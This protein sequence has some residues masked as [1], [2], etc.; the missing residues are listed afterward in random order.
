LNGLVGKPRDKMQE[1]FFLPNAI[2]AHVRQRV[3]RV[4]VKRKWMLYTAAVLEMLRWSDKELTDWIEKISGADADNDF[5]RLVPSQR[6]AVR[7]KDAKVHVKKSRGQSAKDRQ[8]SEA[9]R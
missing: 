1:N 3:E 8:P 9:S 6:G 4:G 5:G 7:A 2:Q